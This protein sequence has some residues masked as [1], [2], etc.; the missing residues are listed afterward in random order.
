MHFILK[1]FYLMEEIGNLKDRFFFLI[2]K[3]CVRTLN[4]CAK[5][6]ET[7]SIT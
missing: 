5:T 1:R 2:T 4:F 6:V 3:N 7:A